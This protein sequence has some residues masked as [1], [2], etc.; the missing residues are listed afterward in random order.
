MKSVRRSELNSIVHGRMT[1]ADAACNSI[2][3]FFS[4]SLCAELKILLNFSCQFV[5]WKSSVVLVYTYTNQITFHFA[6]L[7]TASP[8]F[9]FSTSPHRQF[10][11]NKLQWKWR[12]W[13]MDWAEQI[14]SRSCVL[15]ICFCHCM[16]ISPTLSLQ[17]DFK[18]HTLSI[19]TSMMHWTYQALSRLEI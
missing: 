2:S 5:T 16:K 14:I 17:L 7:F 3:S 10:Q 9:H 8:I 11:S 18:T 1:D 6:T 13:K 12:A 4:L 15:Y 19:D